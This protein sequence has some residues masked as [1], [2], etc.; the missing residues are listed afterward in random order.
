[1]TNERAF[2]ILLL[3][4][5][6]LS[7]SHALA[8]RISKSSV[9]Q[10]YHAGSDTE[11][12]KPLGD[13]PPLHIPLLE[14][15]VRL[16]VTTFDSSE[17]VRQKYPES[18][19]IQQYFH[20][21]SRL[22]IDVLGSVN[23]VDIKNT[24]AAQGC[25]ESP[26]HM[27]YF[28]NPHT[29]KEDLVVH[30]SLL[31]HFFASASQLLS[32]SD[33][34]TLPP[35]VVVTLCDNQPLRWDL[36]ACA[37]SFEFL[38]VAAVPIT[39]ADFPGYSNKRHQSDAHFPYQVM[40]QYYFMRLKDCGSLP[41]DL[42]AVFSSRGEYTVWNDNLYKAQR[43]PLPRKGELLS[44]EPLLPSLSPAL[45][46]FSYGHDKGYCPYI[47]HEVLP[48]LYSASIDDDPVSTGRPLGKS[49]GTAAQASQSSDVSSSLYWSTSSEIGSVVCHVCLRA[50]Q[51]DEE[52]RLHEEELSPS[53]VSN[54]PTSEGL[55][56]S[57]CAPP[58][59]FVDSRALSQHYIVKHS[60]T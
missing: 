19:P 47:C 14:R 33:Q 41:T 18:L 7:F 20:S 48:Q 26:V 13:K 10:R 39:A 35:Q 9:F 29:G 3:G 60:S 11:L 34:P 43:T 58:R 21:K 1:M 30:R 50:F 52:C 44:S 56:C 46:F 15:Y 5:G 45:A 54:S 53:Q 25:H 59:Y 4:E 27:I 40:T 42:Q 28:N 8:R 12:S 55:C 57:R 49:L 31:S 2:R 23:A 37:R 24:L 22:R 36:L 17:E 6:N 51:C 16:L 38:C 32:D